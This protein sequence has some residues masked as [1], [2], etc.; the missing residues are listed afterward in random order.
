MRL[1]YHKL[2]AVD[3]DTA[4]NARNAFV[5][6]LAEIQ[7]R[8]LQDRLD[9]MIDKLADVLM[10]RGIIKQYDTAFQTATLFISQCVWKAVSVH[11]ALAKGTK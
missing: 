8:E 11:A 9:A 4:R 5:D 7:D 10:E 3:N 1:T 6:A 2:D